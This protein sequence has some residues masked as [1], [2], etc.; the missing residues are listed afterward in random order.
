MSNPILLGADLS[1]P[2]YSWSAGENTSYPLSNLKT[3]FPDQVSK[4]NA[5]TDGQSFVIDFGSA[6]ACDAIIL[7]GFNANVMSTAS[8]NMAL[9][10]DDNSGF[11]SPENI[12][13]AG[14]WNIDQDIVAQYQAFTSRT[15]R[16]WRITF[17]KGSA[18]PAAP[19]IGNI[20]LGT[21]LQFETTQEWGYYTNV[22]DYTDGSSE[23]R[24]LDGRSRVSEIFAGI[25]K[26]K[27]S[28]SQS[29]LQS[30]T[31]LASYLTFLRTAKKKPFYYIDNNGSIYLVKW[32]KGFNPPEQFRY[33]QNK[34]V[35]LLMENILAD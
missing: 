7:E 13:N 10:A 26:H 15:Y 5:T 14:A 29:N 23:S 6:K 1:I 30:N 11:T 9:Q 27:I 25:A 32:Q 21:K 12:I 17:N 24:A 20:F 35:D 16:Y 33:N 19:Q 3:Y 34:F 18:L 2:T 31:F 28:F 22:P 4:S 8:V